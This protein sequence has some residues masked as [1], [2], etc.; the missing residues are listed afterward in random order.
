MR[1]YLK[2]KYFSKVLFRAQTLP[3][4]VSKK[5]ENKKSVF[6]KNMQFRGKR[7]NCFFR[8]RLCLQ[9]VQLQQEGSP[10]VLENS[11]HFG[12]QCDGRVQRD[13]VRHAYDG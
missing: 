5:I 10:R 2:L 11:T 4:S 12:R 6:G 13:R 9:A 3:V 7:Y 1:T 8:N